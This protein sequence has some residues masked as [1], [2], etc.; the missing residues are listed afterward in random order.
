MV[1]LFIQMENQAT[2]GISSEN[3]IVSEYR[4]FFIL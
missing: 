3:Q 2:A 4:I 1:P